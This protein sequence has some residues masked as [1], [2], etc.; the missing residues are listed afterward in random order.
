M[1]KK[2]G[3]G[4]NN[5]YI[6]TSEEIKKYNF[7]EWMEYKEQFPDHQMQMEIVNIEQI[8]ITED[9]T[10]T[11]KMAWKMIE[12]EGVSKHFTY[13]LLV[14]QEDNWL[15]VSALDYGSAEKEE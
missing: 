13:F 10:A 4:N 9:F 11:A 14:K 15:I 8:D 1:K 5:L 2:F 3:I 7:D 6:L 12:N